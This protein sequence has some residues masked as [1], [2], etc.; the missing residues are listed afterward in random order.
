MSKVKNNASLL[1]DGFVSMSIDQITLPLENIGANLTSSFGINLSGDIDFSSGNYN[2]SGSSTST[3]SFGSISGDG[4]GTITNIVKDVVTDASPKL[5][6]NIDL[7]G[8]TLNDTSYATVG[9]GNVDYRGIFQAINL[10]NTKLV[11]TSNNLPSGSSLLDETLDIQ[12]SLTGSNLQISASKA[13]TFASLLDYNDPRFS[14]W[15]SNDAGY[16][17]VSENQPTDHTGAQMTGDEW[18]SDQ[19]G[20]AIPYRV[21][22]KSASF[23]DKVQLSGEAIST[24]ANTKLGSFTAAENLDAYVPVQMSSS[25]KIFALEDGNE[26]LGITNQS[27]SQNSSGN[28]TLRGGVRG[29][30]PASLITPTGFSADQLV[31]SNEIA[32]LTGSAQYVNEAHSLHSR[33][34][35]IGLAVKTYTILIRG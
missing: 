1:S 26:F 29:D 3:G 27:I 14:A 10:P 21:L 35:K 9:N 15:T 28:V 22:T 13:I 25:G 2:I 8:Y 19:T 6:A 11:V 23:S 18:A 24:S 34:I 16:G 5:S 12:V 31:V 17:I 4:A 20:I 33:G 30:I 32:W 7:A